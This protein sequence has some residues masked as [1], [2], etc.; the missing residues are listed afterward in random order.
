MIEIMLVGILLVK[1][2]K[3]LLRIKIIPMPYKKLSTLK[4]SK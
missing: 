2:T 4:E 1:E 3:T